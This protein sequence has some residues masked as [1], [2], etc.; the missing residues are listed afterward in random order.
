MA[1]HVASCAP[2]RRGN[3][4]ALFSMRRRL[5]PAMSAG[6]RVMESWSVAP[7]PMGGGGLA[8]TLLS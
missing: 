8:A 2:R 7:I 4:F 3:I 1:H 6:V 5:P